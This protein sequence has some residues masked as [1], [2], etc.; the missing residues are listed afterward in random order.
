MLVRIANLFCWGLAWLCLVTWASASD[1]TSGWLAQP[2]ASEFEAVYPARARRAEVDGRVL[3]RC[4]FAADGTLSNC[5]VLE[6]V[7]VGFGFADASLVLAPKFRRSVGK[8]GEWQNLPFVFRLA[9]DLDTT[10]AAAETS[11][12]CPDG[13]D[14]EVLN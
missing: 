6:E 12:L 11:T 10:G 9:G 1:A 4:Q 14:C 2:T 7:P 8:D 3:L 5:I 13:H